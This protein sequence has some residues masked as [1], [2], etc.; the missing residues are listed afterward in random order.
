MRILV[1]RVG[2]VGDTV[3]MTPALSALLQCYPDADFT[4]VTSP[5]GKN[6][7]KDFH[8][9]I[10]E[11]WPWNRHGIF[12]TH[13]DQKEIRRRAR[14]N[15]FDKI[16][17]FDTNKRIASL[18]SD[19]NSEF[20]WFKGSAILKHNAKLYLEMVASVC[21]CDI[22]SFYNYLPVAEAATRLVNIELE[23]SG[24]RQ[25]DKLVM[26]HPTFSGYSR[27]GL[28]KRDAKIRKLWPAEYYG[29][30]GKKLA[31]TVLQDGTTPKILMA[32]LPAELHYAK[33][34]IAAS[35]GTIQLLESQPTFARYKALIAR[36]DVMLSPD[37]GPMHIAS[38]LGTRIVAFFSRKEPADCGPYMPPHLFTILRSDDPV[39][40]I[41]TIDV[42][43]VLNAVKL[44]L[45]ASIRS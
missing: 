10:R 36:A 11:I 19:L 32:I 31:T 43:T 3:M 25:H 20:H 15:N 6:L 30:L 27:L 17:C 42:E 8:P 1:I 18:F 28:R 29:Q 2:R 9:R 33:K 39:K 16:F 44:Q 7:L 14:L 38:S 26:I 23:S 40:G 37:S 24:I 5:E 22:E 41:S 45:N 35:G 34:I 12:Q 21:N 13:F 4:L